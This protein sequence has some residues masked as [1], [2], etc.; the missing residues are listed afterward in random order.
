MRSLFFWYILQG[1]RTTV[2]L[3]ESGNDAPRIVHGLGASYTKFNNDNVWDQRKKY[4]K[5]AGDNGGGGIGSR[6][7]EIHVGFDN[8][9]NVQS[10]S[11]TFKIGK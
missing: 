7:T 3:S 11:R 1:A 8:K 5:C 4:R 9:Q 10:I 6:C 2:L